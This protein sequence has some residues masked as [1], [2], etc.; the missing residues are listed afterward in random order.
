[1]VMLGR[2]P[3]SHRY[4]RIAATSAVAL[5]AAL[6]LGTAASNAAFPV[7]QNGRIAYERFEGGTSDLWLMN[8]DS[9]GQVPLIAMPGP[10][11]ERTPAFSPLGDKIAFALSTPGNND[12]WIANADGT[13]AANLTNSPSAN[14]FAPAFSPDGKSIV[15]DRT[16]NAQSDIWRINV[17]GSGQVDLTNTPSPTNESQGDYSPSPA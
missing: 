3:M 17:D 5:V 2:H 10:N 9:S 16:Q 1:M 7:S 12:L 8:A 4:I 6:T 11:G 15:F 14:E 13:N